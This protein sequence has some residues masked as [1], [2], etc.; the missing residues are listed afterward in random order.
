MVGWLPEWVEN[1]DP[2]SGESEVFAKCHV[3]F[4]DFSTARCTGSKQV[5]NLLRAQ[6]SF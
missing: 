3:T 6:R 1:A 2:G 4:E 5:L